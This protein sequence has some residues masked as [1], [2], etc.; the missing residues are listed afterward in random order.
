MDVFPGEEGDIR[1]RALG[2]NFVPLCAEG[3][4]RLRIK[5]IANIPAAILEVCGSDLLTCPLDEIYR[6]ANHGALRMGVER[7]LSTPRP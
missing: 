5:R 4:D 6:K 1:M 3:V 2:K 7:I